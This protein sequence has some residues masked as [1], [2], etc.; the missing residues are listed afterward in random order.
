MEVFGIVLCVTFAIAVAVLYSRLFVHNDPPTNIPPSPSPGPSPGPLPGPPPS[1]S[2]SSSTTW[3][4]YNVMPGGYSIKCLQAIMQT[5]GET[6]RIRTNLS[7]YLNPA[8]DQFWEKD[9]RT[10]FDSNPNAIKLYTCLQWA[11]ESDLDALSKMPYLTHVQ[12]NGGIW[13]GNPKS[14][15]PTEDSLVELP[16]FVLETYIS[17]LSKMDAVLNSD[18]VI[19]I[20]FKQFSTAPPGTSSARDQ[21]MGQILSHCAKLQQNKNR[22]I[23]VETTI[24]PFWAL[25]DPSATLNP[26]K[27]V[28]WDSLDAFQKVVSDC[29]T[30][31]GFC[32]RLDAIICETGWPQMCENS[33]GHGSTI[34]NLANARTYYD[35][36]KSY[37]APTNF[38][39]YYWQFQDVDNGDTCGKTW[40]IIDSQSCSLI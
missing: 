27:K 4:G 20:P 2:P 26:D 22:P 39:V 33:T 35:M 15:N 28:L 29:R 32:G 37:P 23:G 38:I 7:S 25:G 12:A 1:P 21:K 40:G 5:Q 16:G 36:V 13:N 8:S 34:A 31:F 9:L 3:L 18:V 14:N 30:Q 10:F 19:V 24:Y 17:W 6:L 11:D